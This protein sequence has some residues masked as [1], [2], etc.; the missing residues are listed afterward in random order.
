MAEVWAE[1][2]SDHGPNRILLP[3]GARGA[4][5]SLARRMRRGTEGAQGAKRRRPAAQAGGPT[6]TSAAGD[7]LIAD[8]HL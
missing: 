3:G 5:N 7:G 1:L 4:S 6:S 2:G 8:G